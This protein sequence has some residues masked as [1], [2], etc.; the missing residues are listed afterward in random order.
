MTTTITTLI[1]SALDL[2]GVRAAQRDWERQSVRN[3][4]RPVK[5]LRHLLV[6]E[7]DRLC[8]AVARDLGKAAEE[9]I[10][11]DLLPLA[12][13]CRF[14]ERSASRLLRP[15][16]VSWRLRPAWLWGQS[17]TVYRRPRGIIGI[18]G[19]WNYP[20][21]L[22]GTEIVQALAAGNGVVWKPSEVAPASAAALQKMLQQ[23]GFPEGLIQVL[24]ATRE[25]GQTLTDTNVDHVVFT[26]SANVGRRIAAHLGERL[27]S[28]TLELS[29]CD[30][31]IVL[32]DADVNLAAR[33]AWFGATVNR[34]QTCLAVRRAFVQRSV[35]PAFCEALRTL[36]ASAS[37]M[38]L[39]LASQVGQTER[40]VREA[41][42]EGGRL[43][44]ES[45]PTN[46]DAD[47]CTMTPAVVV[48]ARP[49]MA[50]CREA[51]FAPVFA[52][53]P[54][55]DVE[56]VLRADRLCS[57]A[58]G[59]SVF[60]RRPE[61]ARELA[62]RLRAGTIAV[63]DVIVP[64]AH[65]ATPFGGNGESGWGVTQGAEGL[66]EMT[67]PQTVSVR[68]GRFR[69]HF[70]LTEGKGASQGA[71]LRGM[72]EAENAATF[73]GRLRGW[74]QVIRSFWRG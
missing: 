37:P 18:I 1:D 60:T 44:V 3:R 67:V 17:D 19:T 28:S 47:G 40:L 15:R 12:A 39:A 72:L 73:G 53:L 13:A 36:A 69:P 11:G 57:F 5:A 4:L 58:L 2:A 20:L 10:G 35:Y 51:A 50:L 38:R 63:N 70:D 22:N 31:Q 41:V 33:A 27:I 14:L 34:G 24:P 32:D 61:R 52:V 46:G 8:D 65:P 26:G 30:A 68:G 49:E 48:D 16:R 25:A 7:C 45:P 64:T 66:L 54:F 9:T 42:A 71:M 23:A 21:F 62:P 55:D 56:E 43:L 29:G 6:A 74:R 59:A